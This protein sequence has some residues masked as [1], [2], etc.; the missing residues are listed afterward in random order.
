MAPS[1][2]MSGQNFKL[3]SFDCNFINRR[4]SEEETQIWRILM[5]NI[6]ILKLLFV[7]PL[8]FVLT[9]GFILLFWYWYVSLRYALLFK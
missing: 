8:L 3:S 4:E 5:L 6:S 9:G 2:I 1:S 7:M